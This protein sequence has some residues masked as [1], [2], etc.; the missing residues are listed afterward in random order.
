VGAVAV[1]V[2]PHG[3][4]AMATDLCTFL[5]GHAKAREHPGF[6]A[7]CDVLDA[8]GTTFVDWLDEANRKDVFSAADLVEADCKLLVAIINQE[9]RRRVGAS[10]PFP[11]FLPARAR[12]RA[13][14]AQDGA[15]GHAARPQ[16]RA[17]SRVRVAPAP[18]QPRRGLRPGRRH[19]SC[20]T[21]LLSSC[22]C[23]V[24]PGSGLN[25][26]VF[27]PVH[28][29]RVPW[30]LRQ[31]HPPPWWH[32]LPLWLHRPLWWHPLWRLQRL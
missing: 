8:M 12:A 20:Y 30:Q 2:A 27:S 22:P 18:M 7:L 9:A 5:A 32:H 3:R 6:S 15:H 26:C 31:P 14:P 23:P 25:P 29:W 1:A 17:Q 4:F 16:A 13:P 24:L 11:P 28:V 10:P 19:I 21:A